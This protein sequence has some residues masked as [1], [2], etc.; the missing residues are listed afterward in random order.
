MEEKDGTVVLE[1]YNEI[2]DLLAVD[3]GWLASLL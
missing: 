1:S 3:R 2:P